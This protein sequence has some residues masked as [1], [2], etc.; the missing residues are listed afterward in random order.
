MIPLRF[1]CFNIH[2]GRNLGG[3]RDLKR[4][5]EVMNLHHVDIGVF[6]EMETRKI[7]GGTDQDIE[8]LAGPE[9][10]YHLAGPS[11]KDE[12]GWYGN[13]L[14]SRYPIIRGFIHNLETK[15]KYEPRCAID[16]LIETPM[17]KIRVIG[18]HLSLAS[19]ERYSEVKN[20]LNLID[21]VEETEKN[22]LFLMGD[23][24]EWRE[25]SKLLRHLNKTMIAL[26]CQPSF[27]SKF[28]ILKLDR[29][30]HDTPNLTIKAQTLSG[31]GLKKLSDHLPLLIEAAN[32]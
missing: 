10:P 17:G 8:I 5:N 23:M 31:N 19:W 15:I 16:A 9:R 22:P 13:L 30:W 24:N 32:I 6:Q 27:P 26:P 28:P 12:T 1:L 21:K 11:L 2:G 18:T 14:V 3:E 29:A 4:L 25:S 20:L 7:R